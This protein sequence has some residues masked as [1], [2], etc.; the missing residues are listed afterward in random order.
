MNAKMPSGAA[1][2]ADLY[3]SLSTEHALC[4]D[5]PAIVAISNAG[6]EG[7]ETPQ[8]RWAHAQRVRDEAMLAEHRAAELPA[9]PKPTPVS[10]VLPAL[11]DGS[12]GMHPAIVRDDLFGLGNDPSRIYKKRYP[13]GNAGEYIE[14]RGPGLSPWHATVFY[15]LLHERKGMASGEPIVFS[16]RAFARKIGWADAG[17]SVERL[18]E[19]LL[20]MNGSSFV[21]GK[22]EGEQ[23]LGGVMAL[24]K[25]GEDFS[26]DGKHWC[27]RLD[28]GAARLFAGTTTYI[29]ISK[30]KQL[31][32]GLQTWLFD[33]LSSHNLAV[34]FRLEEL[35]RRSG[36]KMKDLGE[37]GNEVTDAL[38]KIKRVGGIKGFKREIV[39]GM[40]VVRCWRAGD[41]D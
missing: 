34:P 35:R 17:R 24:V 6:E 20:L 10:A 29:S 37:F 1:P 32:E 12:Y 3:A 7:T 22:G 21:I 26:V 14:Y 36:S 38:V 15:A 41:F 19:C 9:S 23:F 25:I 4:D 39:K 31:R 5:M 11:Y 30:R 16:P 18:R 33:H 27:V 8:E 40:R 2:P 28:E 13:V